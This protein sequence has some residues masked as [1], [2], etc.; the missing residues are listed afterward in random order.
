MASLVGWLQT[1]LQCMFL[2]KLEDNF[3]AVLETMQ[4]AVIRKCWKDYL[5][6][7]RLRPAVCAILNNLFFV[8]IK[9]CH[10]CLHVITIANFSYPFQTLE[11]MQEKSTYIFMSSFIQHVQIKRLPNCKGSVSLIIVSK[12]S[13]K[14][15]LDSPH[16]YLSFAC[17]RYCQ[18]IWSPVM[19]AQLAG[20]EMVMQ[21]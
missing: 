14:W 18:C 3:P 17:L 13:C 12:W 15:V 5:S 20:S 6:L 2:R 16:A 4:S 8:Q 1:K 10:I 11:L 9:L 21:W 19:F 7:I